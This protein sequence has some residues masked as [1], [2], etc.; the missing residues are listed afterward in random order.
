M[1]KALERTQKETLRAL[2]NRFLRTIF[3]IRGPKYNVQ[4]RAQRTRA[5]GKGRHHSVEIV[6]RE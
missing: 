3:S 5:V 2:V 1:L 6:S 4:Q